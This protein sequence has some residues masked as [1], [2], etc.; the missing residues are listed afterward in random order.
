LINNFNHKT[1]FYVVKHKFFLDKI[2]IDS[3]QVFKKDLKIISIKKTKNKIII[4]TNSKETDCYVGVCD[5][6]K[7]NR[8]RVSTYIHIPY[9]KKV[10]VLDDKGN[11]MKEYK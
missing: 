1:G 3:N 9:N 7:I 10:V 4:K 8:Q 11:E 5:I 6:H 2:Y